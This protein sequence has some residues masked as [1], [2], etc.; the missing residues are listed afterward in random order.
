MRGWMWVAAIIAVLMIVGLVAYAR[1]PDH[2]RGDDVGALGR[3]TVIVAASP[4]R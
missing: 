3:A 4:T 1:G 2:H